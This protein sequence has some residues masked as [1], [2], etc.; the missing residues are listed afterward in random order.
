MPNKWHCVP[1]TSSA[2]SHDLRHFSP[3]SSLCYVPTCDACG[4]IS[5][6]PGVLAMLVASDGLDKERP[7]APVPLC[8]SISVGCTSTSGLSPGAPSS[9]AG[10]RR[11]VALSLALW[12]AAELRA[13][14]SARA[15]WVPRTAS[16][17][18][19]KVLPTQLRPLRRD[20]PARS[21]AD[22]SS[23][24][25][26]GQDPAHLCC[27]ESPPPAQR[28]PPSTPCPVSPAPGH[29]VS[30]CGNPH[31]SPTWSQIRQPPCSSRVQA[32]PLRRCRA[33][34]R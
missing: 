34:A 6:L 16:L 21:G 19:R 22:N 2:S 5:L 11:G 8:T 26:G 32:E 10:W 29:S 13:T 3:L 31:T 24:G 12:P 33:L 1:I 7:R 9:F 17:L 23:S 18:T 25:G 14:T 20:H 15:I 28:A 27:G 30:F 4:L